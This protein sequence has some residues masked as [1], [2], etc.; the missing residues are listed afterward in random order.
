M[1]DLYA[2]DFAAASDEDR[3]V[4]ALYLSDRARGVAGLPPPP[5][6]VAA[7][8]GL[9]PSL[10]AMPAMPRLFGSS[11]PM[12]AFEATDDPP[13]PPPPAPQQ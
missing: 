5:D 2:K 12:T 1:N 7:Q 8:G 9:L 4:A 3:Q 13:P 6:A 10:P 11:P